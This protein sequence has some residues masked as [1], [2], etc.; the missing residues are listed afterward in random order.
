M[1]DPL[2]AAVSE[3]RNVI[4]EERAVR[5]A[6]LLEQ[7]AGENEQQLRAMGPLRGVSRR[8]AARLLE[9]ARQCDD[10]QRV[11]ELIV[12]AVT[13]LDDGD[14]LSKGDVRTALGDDA[15]HCGRSAFVQQNGIRF[16][17]ALNSAVGSGRI[18]REVSGHVGRY[19]SN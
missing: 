16:E 14:G 1:T 10:V 18:R 3:L 19:Y 2:N 5:R 15:L 9:A 4:S 17:K 12:E 7:P 13:V 8:D 6:A 11:V